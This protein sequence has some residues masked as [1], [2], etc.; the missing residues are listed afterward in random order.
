M[1]ASKQTREKEIGF[2][3]EIFLMCLGCYDLDTE[4]LSWLAFLANE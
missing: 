2:V 4:Q 3:S 1:N